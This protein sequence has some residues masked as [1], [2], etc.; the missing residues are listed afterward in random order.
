MATGSGEMCR[1][2]RFRRAERAFL[3]HG[4][5]T[6]GNSLSMS[7][8]DEYRRQYAWRDWTRGLS[9]CPI[10]KGQN[11]L[12]LGCGPGD[13]SAELSARGLSVTGIDSNSELLTGARERCPQCRFE[14]QNLNG[15]HLTPAS[16][17]GIWCSFTA[18]YFVDFEKTFS[19]WSSFLKP[20]AWV[21]IVDIDDLLGHEPLSEKTKRLINSFYEDALRGGRYDFRV[22]RK[23]ESVLKHHGF[24]VISVRLQDEELSFNGPAH[25][26][27][28]K[29]WSDRF[30]RMG[31]LRA[32]LGQKLPAFEDE[33]IRCLSSE[34]HRSLCTVVCCIGTRK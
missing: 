30:V 19:H 9:L 20:Q 34:E 1:R 32:F 15:L 16:Y 26:D 4:V 14:N 13:L 25:P 28:I 8:I 5:V 6:L 12:D 21:G 3:F 10:A 17:D 24:E 11:V 33:F 29:A 27:V 31:G 2:A 18:A 22:G 23:M 7:L